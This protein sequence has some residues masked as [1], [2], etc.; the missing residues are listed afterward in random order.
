MPNTV[1]KE[2]GVWTRLGK[3][4]DGAK[5]LG[6]EEKGKV[7]LWPGGR[8]V[9]GQGD[10]VI[11]WCRRLG[12]KMN[13]DNRHRQGEPHTAATALNVPVR[14]ITPAHTC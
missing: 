3:A 8:R 1:L 14:A 12:R 7:F 6:V 11:P 13:R 4:Q 5:F 2:R 9:G 10:E